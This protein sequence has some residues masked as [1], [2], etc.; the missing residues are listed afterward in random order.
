MGEQAQDRMESAWVEIARDLGV[1]VPGE[2][3]R[4]RECEGLCVDGLRGVGGENRPRRESK[5]RL[6]K[7]L[8]WWN[9]GFGTRR[10]I[11]DYCR[12]QG[13][14]PLIA[15]EANS[16]SAIIEIV[17][18]TALATILPSAIAEDMSSAVHLVCNGSEACC[19]DG[20][21]AHAM[22]VKP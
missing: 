18:S 8:V 9:T 17:R 21:L 3:Q 2:H 4:K 19:F 16:I 6:V 10:Y 12:A 7:P 14:S 20:G 22:E 11:D 13:I 5:Q 1:G 15:M